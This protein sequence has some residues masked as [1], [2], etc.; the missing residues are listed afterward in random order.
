MQD[1]EKL[2]AFY[3]G[4]MYDMK[5]QKVEDDILLYDAKDLTTHAVC[6]GMTGSGKTGLCLALLE[7]AAIDGIPALVIDPKGDISNLL[8]TFPDLK[9]EDFQPWIDPAE[10]TRKGVTPEEL[11]KSTAETWKKGLG[12]WGQEPERIKKFRDSVDI[13]VYTPGSTAGLPVSILRSFSAPQ[14]EMRSDAEAFQGKISAAVSGLLALLQIDADPLQSR[15]HILL[16]NILDH[17]WREGRSPDLPTLIREIQSPP[18][19]KLGVLDLESA[20]PSKDRFALSMRLNNL[21][22]SPG[23][24]AWLQGEPLD[25]QRM[26]YSADGKPRISILSIAHLS[27]AERMFFVTVLLNEVISW[28]RSQ[29]GTSSLRALLYMD[30]VFG[31]FPPTANPPSKT[32]MLLLLKQARAFGLGIVLATQNPVD[33][34]YKGLANAGTWFLGRLQTERDKARVLDGL[35]GASAA[36]GSSFDR[37][38]MDTILSGLGNRVFLMNNVHDD[39]PV[40]FQTRW[41]LSY[42]RGPLTLEQVRGLMQSRKPSTADSASRY[43]SP[44]IGLSGVGARP[45]LPPGVTEVFIP[46]RQLLPKGASLVYKPALAGKA[47]VH[48]AKAG[49]GVDLWKTLSILAQVDDAVSATVWDEAEVLTEEEHELGSEP[50]GDGQFAPLPP[51]LSQAKKYAQITNFLRD[52]LYRTQAL[53]LWTCAALKQTSKPE[54]SEGDFRARISHGSRENRDLQIEKLRAKYAP[55]FAALDERKRK[56]LQRV[57]KEKSQATQSSMSAAISFGTSM[58]GALFGRKLKSAANVGRAATSMRSA[59]RVMREREDV[60]QAEENVEAIDKRIAELDAEFQAETER[61]E[62]ATAPDA[63]KLDEIEIKP[64]KADINVMQVALAWVPYQV[65][66]SG[67]AKPLR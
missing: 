57:E 38:K 27:D 49:T 9:P 59:G 63:L 25:I 17:A 18:F 58:L 61:L 34:D 37:G 42:L 67:M 54:E 29:P 50:E 28:M 7:E 5:K 53:K 14:P 45:V 47:Q 39:A 60:A 19:D 62:G 13:S 52:S 40:V 2:G 11:A 26:L 16:S 51:D 64:K 30:E 4:R 65:D 44:T 6:V 66:A 8:L 35:E 10:A 36:A 3:L 33:L 21:V 22:A 12:D 24:A 23:F 15:E 41:V 48:F 20:F 55:K 43:E 1:F 56:A 32:P 46:G 31:Y